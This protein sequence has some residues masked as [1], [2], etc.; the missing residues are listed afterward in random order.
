MKLYIPPIFYLIAI[1]FLGLGIATYGIYGTDDFL[2]KNRPDYPRDAGA[3][4]WFAGYVACPPAGGTQCVSIPDNGG[5][6]PH[7]VQPFAINDAPFPLVMQWQSTCQ[8][9]KDVTDTT[10]TFGIFVVCH[11]GAIPQ[12]QFNPCWEMFGPN[13]IPDNGYSTALHTPLGGQCGPPAA[14]IA[15][16]QDCVSGHGYG[17]GCSLPSTTCTNSSFYHTDTCVPR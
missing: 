8:K 9:I 17:F 14:I 11:S 10:G 5:G 6:S 4:G 1:L 16:Y 12:T 2:T 7:S 3:R 13:H 15:A